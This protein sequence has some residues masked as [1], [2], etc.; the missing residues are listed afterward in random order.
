[1]Y[2]LTLIIPPRDLASIPASRGNTCPHEAEMCSFKCG[3]ELNLCAFRAMP[4]DSDVAKRR[5]SRKAW[6][7]IGLRRH[8]SGHEEAETRLPTRTS[9]SDVR[10][11]RRVRVGRHGT[12]AHKFNLSPHLKRT[13]LPMPSVSDVASRRPSQ[14]ACPSRKAWNGTR[15][16]S[17]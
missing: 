9:R 3:L 16:S 2:P 1:M 8:G 14:K 4:S 6:E 13:R 7:D 5:L 15:T 10:V 17:T 12:E 11:G